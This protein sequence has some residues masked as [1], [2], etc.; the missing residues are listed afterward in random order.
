MKIKDYQ[1]KKVFCELILSCKYLR[2]SAAAIGEDFEKSIS[3][4]RWDRIALI[5]QIKYEL[6]W[7]LKDSKDFVEY[8]MEVIIQDNTFIKMV[9]ESERQHIISR[10]G[11]EDFGNL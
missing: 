4:Y 6:N 5:K 8:M 11:I 1:A 2:P 9:A 3:L 7:G 10:Q